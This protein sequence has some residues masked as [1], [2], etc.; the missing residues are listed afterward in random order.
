MLYVFDSDL[1]LPLLGAMSQRRADAVEN[2][3]KLLDAA[4]AIFLEL[5]TNASLATQKG[6]AHYR[7][8]MTRGGQQ[9]SDDL[10]ERRPKSVSC[11]QFNRLAA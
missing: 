8:A 6:A 3:A 11:E 7:W 2:R 4:E 10:C 9:G 5:G 1:F